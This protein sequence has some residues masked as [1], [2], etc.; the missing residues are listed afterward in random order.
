MEADAADTMTTLFSPVTVGKLEL[1]DRIAMAPRTRN[2]AG[3]RQV[4]QQISA[5][6]YGQRASAGLIIT[7][8]TQPRE[9][10]GRRDVRA[11]ALAVLTAR[12]VSHSSGESAASAGIAIDCSQTSKLSSE[13]TSAPQGAAAFSSGTRVG[14][15][16][17]QR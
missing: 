3:E 10:A 12:A 13:T 6:H 1:A 4:P 7:E 17:G 14:S 2:R 5:T 9:G 11:G 15:R 8:G 16:R